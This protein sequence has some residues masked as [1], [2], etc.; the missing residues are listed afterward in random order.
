MQLLN[1]KIKDCVCCVNSQTDAVVSL[2]MMRQIMCG[3]DAYT[4]S[5]S[6]LIQE[7]IIMCSK[8]RAETPNPITMTA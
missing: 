1:L 2:K 6:R 7:N 3:R 4:A 8:E 5:M